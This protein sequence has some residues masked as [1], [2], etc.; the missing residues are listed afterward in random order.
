MGAVRPGN[1]VLPQLAVIGFGGTAATPG[2]TGRLISQCL[3]LADIASPAADA[4]SVANLASADLGKPGVQYDA[5][6]GAGVSYVLKGSGPNGEQVELFDI[7]SKT[8]ILG[9]AYASASAEPR[10]VALR[11]TD[12]VMKAM[13]GRPGIFSSRIAYLTGGRNKDIVITE[14]D[15][16]GQRRLIDDRALVAAPTWGKL[17]TEIYFTSYRDNNPDLYGIT[18]DGRRWDISRRPGQNTSADW[19]EAAGRIAASLSKDG[20]P[21]IYSMNREGRGLSRLT[22]SP[23][24][25]TAPAWSPDGSQ[26]SFTSDRDGVPGIYVMGANGGGA[27]RVSPAGRYADGASWS[28]DGQRLAYSVREQGAFNIH[29]LDLSSGASVAVARGAMN[30]NPSWGASSRHLVFSSTRS[31]Q[32]QL[33]LL[34]IDTRQA[35]PIP[36]TAGAQE[37]AWGP[38]SP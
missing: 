13:T 37:P 34:N 17:G 3:T 19:S 9:Q 18:L 27:R 31:G 28:P 6:A 33:F 22:T 20:N 14:P 12:D 25:V 1:L 30:T 21:E 35:R 8:R 5:W 4:L 15:G 2:N 32:R 36:G 11:I 16:Q 38:V 26:I 23:G 10:R 7:P 29:V 24:G